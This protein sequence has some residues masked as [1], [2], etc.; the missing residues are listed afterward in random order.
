V[1][2]LIFTDS[3]FEDLGYF[4]KPDRQRILSVAEARLSFEPDCPT[5]HRKVLRPNPLAVWEL[6]VGDFRVFYDV[7][8]AA[9]EV[10]IAAVGLKVGNR[11]LIRGREVGL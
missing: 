3:A 5:R 9:G 8:D 4:R 6:R 2:Q 1:F 10:R 7:D 11:L